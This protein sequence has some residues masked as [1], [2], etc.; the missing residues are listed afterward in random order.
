MDPSAMDVDSPDNGTGVTSSPA[1]RHMPSVGGAGAASGASGSGTAAGTGGAT[2]MASTQQRD[3]LA[4]SDISLAELVALMDEYKPLV[5]DAVTDHFLA[6]AGLDCDDVRVKR[7]LAL[8]AQKFIADIATD[9]LHFSK[10]RQPTQPASSR[11]A[12]KPKTQL[13]IEDLSLALSEYGVT[14]KKPD[15]YS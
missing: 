13:T 6:K 2:G 10:L 15:Y 9:A 11:K 12:S 4:R 14:I 5:P 1:V 3:D 8:A 7:I